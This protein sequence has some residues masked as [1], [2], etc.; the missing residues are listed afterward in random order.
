MATTIWLGV[1]KDTN[2]WQFTDVQR[3]IYFLWFVVL[4]FVGVIGIIRLIAGWM[5]VEG[6]QYE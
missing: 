2:L 5:E 1:I 6:E 4:F 3:G